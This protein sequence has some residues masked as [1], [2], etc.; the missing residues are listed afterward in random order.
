MGGLKRDGE[1]GAT[2]NTSEAKLVHQ[3]AQVSEETDYEQVMELQIIE[4]HESA[5]RQVG[6]R[7]ETKR[8]RAR[9]RGKREEAVWPR[10]RRSRGPVGREGRWRSCQNLCDEETEQDSP[11]AS[12]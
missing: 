9:E 4:A 11:V 7:P 8:G 6:R 10:A 1:E 3:R 2:G 12:P 5:G